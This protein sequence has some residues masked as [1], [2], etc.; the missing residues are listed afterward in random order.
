MRAVAKAVF[1]LLL[2]TTST[3]TAAALSP[4]YAPAVEGQL[5]AGEQFNI[6][7]QNSTPIEEPLLRYRE[8]ETTGWK[9]CDL[10][11]FTCRFESGLR[12]GVYEF[13]FINR[14][15]ASTRFPRTGYL[16]FGISKGNSQWKTFARNFTDQDPAN[17]GFGESCEPWN[18]NFSC[19]FE[20][21]NSIMASAFG[22]AETHTGNETYSALAVNMSLIEYDNTGNDAGSEAYAT[23][24]INNSDY[25]CGNTTTLEPGGEDIPPSGKRQGWLIQSLSATGSRLNNSNITIEGRNYMNGSAENC[26]IWAGDYECGTAAGQGLMVLGSWEAYLMQGN[27]TYRDKAV[28][29]S[30]AAY[31]QAKAIVN[32]TNRT[33][34]HYLSSGL[35]RAYELTDN[36]SYRH[37]AANITRQ[38]GDRCVN[39]T[40]TSNCSVE[41]QTLAVMA[42][43]DGYRNTEDHYY[44]H[45]AASH[46]KTN[47][48]GTC[49]P[50]NGA[51]QC[52]RA[53]R[54]GL[55]A[56]AF[57]ESYSLLPVVDPALRAPRIVSSRKSGRQKTF[58]IGM[59]GDVQDP[60][61]MVRQFNASGWRTCNIPHH[62]R[63][64]TIEGSFFSQQGIYE[65]R[66]NSSGIVFPRNG[67]FK[68]I[69][70][71]QNE[72]I[73][74]RAINMT[75]TDP[76]FG[77][78]P[79]ENDF[80]CGNTYLQALMV[81]GF[82]DAVDFSS[83]ATYRDI[84]RELAT[85]NVTGSGSGNCLPEENDFDC[86][87]DSNKKRNGSLIQGSMIQ[88]LWE[89]YSATGNETVQRLALNYTQGNT[90]DCD[91]WSGDYD[92]GSDRGQGAMIQGMTS[93]YT[94]TGNTTYLDHATNLSW[95]AAQQTSISS[96]LLADGLWTVY[97][98]TSNESYRSTADGSTQSL[99]DSCLD[100]TC[101]ERNYSTTIKTGFTA[102][103]Q[104]G[105]ETYYNTSYSIL[106]SGLDGTCDPWD[107]SFQCKEPFQQG[108]MISVLWN[109]F[110]H[111]KI[112]VEGEV[113]LSVTGTLLKPGDAIQATCGVEN[114]VVNG[115]DLIGTNLSLDAPGFAVDGNTTVTVGDIEPLDSANHTWNLTADT[116]GDHDV[117]CTA[118][119]ENDWSGSDS[120][121]V[122]VEEEEETD[123]SGGSG[124]TTSSTGTTGGAPIY[125][126]EEVLYNFTGQ[127][128]VREVRQL[129][130]AYPVLNQSFPEILD[131]NR[132]GRQRVIRA[133]ADASPC[134]QG[135]RTFSERE[136]SSWLETN[137]SCRETAERLL[138]VD[139]VPLTFSRS[140]NLTVTTDGLSRQLGEDPGTFAH[141]WD[142][143]TVDSTVRVTY[144]TTEEP[145]SDAFTAPLVLV[146]NHSEPVDSE[147]P[148][149]TIDLNRTN[150]TQQ[151]IRLKTG[152]SDRSNVTCTVFQDN[153][154][155]GT[156]T[157]PS[158]LEYDLTEGWNVFRIECQDGSGNTISERFETLMEAG[159]DESDTTVEEPP[160]SRRTDYTPY[161]VMVLSILLISGM[162]GVYLRRDLIVQQYHR[163]QLQRE[164]DRINSQIGGADPHTIVTTYERI[165]ELYRRYHGGPP[166]ME[167]WEQNLSQLEWTIRVYLLFDLSLNRME[168]GDVRSMA[169]NIPS[170]K[171]LYQRYQEKTGEDAGEKLRAKAEQLE[172]M[173][174]QE[175][176]SRSITD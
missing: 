84:D 46:L 26:D 61:M 95:R 1:F 86:E 73:R 62:N 116:T 77:C 167:F 24:D 94:M 164:I 102:H 110:S 30:E 119:S 125:R 169:Q 67:T 23:C 20:H 35:W 5:L 66:F 9:T 136:Q 27:E 50:W 4:L 159:T 115:S 97:G 128:T 32:D 170:L 120:V 155:L 25:D 146:K 173:L 38:L 53:D 98:L 76:E 157:D 156:F 122:T 130:A 99:L 80:I 175:G 153:R 168:Q 39:R 7:I 59:K 70:G 124:S 143:I 8:H 96:Q 47:F 49:N 158:E 121:T 172:A 114:T 163:Y 29:L 15:N 176:I 83:N 132:A 123:D 139:T 11:N 91:V 6:S 147:P 150:M 134:L 36:Q 160:G 75:G 92:C 48:S 37:M 104:S 44:F 162:A 31:S 171:R 3:I 105:N 101:G 65:Y 55:A 40:G 34:S 137:Y 113:N 12:Q 79:W 57:W 111:S 82:A 64:C 68:E 174:Q 10:K 112:D 138:V 131:V 107:N 56:L 141:R 81:D 60:V 85:S 149:L 165:Q 133:T 58:R 42:A 151:S 43:L 2:L 72:S 108:A 28:E 166:D 135:R 21:M 106:E 54:Q 142:D 71:H 161:I 117:A 16:R 144:N 87:A 33:G 52:E 148:N 89:S 109:A 18:G 93:A 51:F 103:M 19:G 22:M 13:Y 14:S 41:N 145:G 126:T 78:K 74:S 140:A 118:S 88:G 152:V 69:I 63:S 17:S 154:T 100:G 127:S 129:L 45:L 90:S